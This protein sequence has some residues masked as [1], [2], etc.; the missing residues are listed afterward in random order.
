M[1]RPGFVSPPRPAA[2]TRRVPRARTEA[3][4]ELVR[5]EFERARLE[6]ELRQLA[7]RQARAETAIGAATDRATALLA[8]LDGKDDRP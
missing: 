7:Q 8:R 1:R 6:R 4:V 5:V 3:A 2:G